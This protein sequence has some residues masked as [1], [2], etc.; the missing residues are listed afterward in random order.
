MLSLS[1]KLSLNTIK[2]LGKWSPSDEASLKA[3]WKN[4]TGVSTDGVGVVRWD[5]QSGNNLHFGQTLDPEK[6]TYAG[7]TGIN[8]GTLTFNPAGLQ[9]LDC[10]QITF[11]QGDA[12]TIGIRLDVNNIGGALLADNSSPGEVMR[13]TS[14]TELRLKFNNGTAQN[15]S[16][17]SGSFIGTR[18][19]VVTRDSG[20]LCKL[21]ADGVEQS[22]T[23]TDDDSF[24]IDNFGLRRSN[25]NPYDGK[26]M[27]VQI[28]TDLGTELT[29]NVY[30]SL[31]NIN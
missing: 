8:A 7:N 4:A 14:T 30:N 9:N 12:F 2:N 26:L 20:G 27:E 6:P 13:L 25:L 5:D 28:Y 11:A 3:W 16:L 15:L 23:K 22:T 24:L 21:F 17:D 19:I 31:K 29:N 18:V 1:Q 10:P